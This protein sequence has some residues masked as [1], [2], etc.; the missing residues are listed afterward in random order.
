VSLALAASD[1]DGDDLWF[2]ARGLPPGLV[3]DRE[4][5]VISG[6]ATLPGTYAVVV[7]A[8]D[9]PAVDSES[10]E[11]QVHARPCADAVDNDGDGAVD[12]PADPGC[13]LASSP[14]EAPQ[15]QDGID[16]DRQP[17]STSTA[18][19]RST[20]PAALAY[21]LPA[22]AT[23]RATASQTATRTAARRGAT[24]SDRRPAASASS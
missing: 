15:C 10:F 5:G 24:T 14:S 1:A 20:A 18:A 6:A 22:S 17:G 8:S 21:A 2:E 19:S 23:R 13:R 11:W 3:L 7:G 16:N 12:Y 9:G 4:A